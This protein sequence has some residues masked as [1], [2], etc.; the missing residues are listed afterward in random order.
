[1][2]P[3]V[4]SPSARVGGKT[5]SKSWG[6]VTPLL[7]SCSPPPPHRKATDVER[8]HGDLKAADGKGVALTVYLPRAAGLSRARGQA[9]WPGG[10]SC[11]EKSYGKIKVPQRLSRRQRRA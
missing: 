1:M 4:H 10:S 9:A 6:T 7:F 5:P 3:C 2:L 8:L 11:D